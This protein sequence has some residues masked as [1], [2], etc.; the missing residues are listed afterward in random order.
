M[1]QDLN[2]FSPLFAMALFTVMI[3]C[4]FGLIILGSNL[5]SSLVQ[6]Q[7]QN[8]TIRAGL[9]YLSTSVHAADAENAISIRNGP[10]GDALVLTNSESG[11]ETRIYLLNGH[12]VEE[13]SPIGS[14][15]STD[16]A[17]PITEMQEFKPCFLSA[18][19]LSIETSSG[20]V[21]IALHSSQE[22][23]R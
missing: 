11:Y 4:I 19:L 10:Q 17:Q 14:D 3:G 21:R 1:K 16:D 7:T 2:R 6:S 15:F 9:C 23:T 8:N 12:L 13:L 20:T 18:Q 22:G 5:Y